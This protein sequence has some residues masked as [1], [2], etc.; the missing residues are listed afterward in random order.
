MKYTVL[1][2][3]IDGELEQLSIE[4]EQFAT[5]DYHEAVIAADEQRRLYQMLSDEYIDEVEVVTLPINLI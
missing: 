3:T 2:T 5:D 4:G 1:L